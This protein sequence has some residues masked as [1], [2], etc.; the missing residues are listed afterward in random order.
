MLEQICAYIHNY[1]TH[2][3]GLELDREAG[4][5]TIADGTIE[6]GFL[7]P[8]N[9]FL[10]RGS[11]FNDGVHVYPD[12]AMND[13]TFEGVIYKMAPDVVFLQTV[14][15]IEAWQ[16]K[17]GTAVSSPYQ[18]ENFADYGYNMSGSRTNGG[19][20]EKPTWQ[21]TFRTRLIPWRK[22]YEHL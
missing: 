20:T 9:Y 21:S 8:G 13:E 17:Y 15:D 18:S 4:E 16:D 10:I 1:F 19:T 5:F 12:Y 2:K 3:N 11:D 7:K 14:K 22:L 6:I